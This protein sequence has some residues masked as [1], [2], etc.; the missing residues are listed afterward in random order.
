MGLDC[1]EVID[2]YRQEILS[3]FYNDIV[4]EAA[5]GKVDCYINYNL[6]FNTKI[7]EMG[8]DIV[9]NYDNSDLLVPTLFI[10]NKQEFED[11]LLLYVERALVFY[12]DS[13][14]I[15]EILSGEAKGNGISKE[16]VIM[17]LLWS[18]ATIDDFNNPCSYLKR[19]ISFFELGDLERYERS[20]IVGYSEILDA[21]IGCYICENKIESETPYSLQIYLKDGNDIVYEF[22]RI[23]FGVAD[24][25]AYFYAIQN[26]RQRYVEPKRGKRIERKMYKVNDGLEDNDLKDITASFLVAINIVSGIL[27]NHQINK[28][29]I[30]SILVSRWNAKI[31]VLDYRKNKL[32]SK[33]DYDEELIQQM[34]NRNIEIQKNLTDKFLRTFRRLKYHHSSI[35]IKCYPMEIDSNLHLIIY[36]RDDVC[37]NKLLEETYQVNKNNYLKK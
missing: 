37:N 15:E 2:M 16:K 3:I 36:E 7:P 20:Q 18:N 6:I 11:L 1:M 10:K 14:F 17:T 5:T 24:D 25:T 26:H 21:G 22:P 35:G 13:N 19:R 30:A 29:S 34:Y 8:I 33:G 32:L 9:S 31:M 4:P 12:D 27:N 23:Y 28:F